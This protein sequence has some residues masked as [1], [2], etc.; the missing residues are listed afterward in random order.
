[1]AAL[2]LRQGLRTI[3]AGAAIGALA[4]LALTRALRAQL[5]GISASDPL[6]Y[7]AV[8][9]ALVAAALLACYLPARRATRVDPVEA[10]RCD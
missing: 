7:A 2:I 9:L 5:Y 10:L 6:T 8:S 3:L 4:S 1:V